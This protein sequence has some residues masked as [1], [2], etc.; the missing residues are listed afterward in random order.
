[1]SIPLSAVLV[2][3][4]GLG[5]GYSLDWIAKRPPAHFANLVAGFVGV[6]SYLVVRTTFIPFQ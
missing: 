1:M 2:F 3:L 4:A 6:I 5:L